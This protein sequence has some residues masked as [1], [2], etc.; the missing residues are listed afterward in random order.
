MIWWW[1]YVCGNISGSSTSVIEHCYIVKR[2]PSGNGRENVQSMIFFI[3]TCTICV[4]FCLD[5]HSVTFARKILMRTGEWNEEV[6]YGEQEWGRW[7][8]WGGA[9]SFASPLY[10]VHYFQVFCSVAKRAREPQVFNENNNIKRK[11]TKIS[12][13]ILTLY[14]II[15]SKQLVVIDKCGIIR[16]VE[17]GTMGRFVGCLWRRQ[18]ILSFMRHGFSHRSYFY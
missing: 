13:I 16:L 18:W 12:E 9:L 8:V 2:L 3:V 11:C 1:F 14:F 6:K 5:F 7:R 15:T 4:H 17:Y 10:W